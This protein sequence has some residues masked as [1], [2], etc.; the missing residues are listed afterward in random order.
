MYNLNDLQKYFE[1]LKTIFANSPSNISLALDSHK[2]LI[3]VGYNTENQC[4]LFTNPNS[5]TKHPIKIN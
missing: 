2:H 5:L 3:H 4:W 1:E